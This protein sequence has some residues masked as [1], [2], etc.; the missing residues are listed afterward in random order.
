MICYDAST[1]E[2]DILPKVVKMAKIT[3]RHKQDT[4]D[5]IVKHYP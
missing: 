5:E 4:P 2:D 3:I 1:K